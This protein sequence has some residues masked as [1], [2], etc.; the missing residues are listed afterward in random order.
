MAT[1]R[2]R[3]SLSMPAGDLPYR[4]SGVCAMCLKQGVGMYVPSL[5]KLFCS[6]LCEERYQLGLEQLDPKFY[7]HV[8]A[9]PGWPGM[10]NDRRELHDAVAFGTPV[11]A[12]PFPFCED[13]VTY[14]TPLVAT[15]SPLPYLANLPTARRHGQARTDAPPF[16]GL[17]AMSDTVDESHHAKDSAADT[18]LATQKAIDARRRNTKRRWGGLTD[19]D[20]KL[21]YVDLLVWAAIAM[22]F[23]WMLWQMVGYVHGEYL[24]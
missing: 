8:G 4:E 1:V 19:D 11:P 3:L 18:Y 24:R 16:G 10:T 9:Q 7:R 14:E 15:D 17:G 12:P 6:Q 2:S 23:G 5:G 21:P 13:G 20:K 22:I